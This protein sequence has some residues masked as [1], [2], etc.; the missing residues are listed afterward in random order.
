MPR[1]LVVYFSQGGT[2]ARVAESIAAGL[3]A[4]EWQ[5]T[6]CNLKDTKPPAFDG[7][8]LL[9]IGAP[10]YY[11]R[12]PFKVMDYLNNLPRLDGLPTL[13]FV[14]YGTYMGDTGNAIRRVLSRKGAREVGYFHCYGADFYLP[15]LKQGYL[16]SPDHPTAE[17][18]SRAESFGR[19][20]AGRIASHEYARAKED[21]SPAIMYRLE[22]FLT[23]RWLTK[24]VWSRLFR[25]DD[26]RCTSCGLCINLCPTGNIIEGKQGRPTLG[27]KCLLCL[28]CEMECPE[29]A[30]TSPPTGPLFRPF[31]IYNVRHASRD[32]SLE[33]VRVKHSQGRTRRV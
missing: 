28:T 20:A 22:R 19:E 23:N 30:I 24:Q 15:Y 2:T 21:P 5:V 18:L 13:V 17:E 1:S 9:G 29:E 26:K 14:L 32:P 33:H 7:Y 25:V 4:M 3:R 8:D 12:A 16:F 31:V 27:R 10:A 6:L 11:Y